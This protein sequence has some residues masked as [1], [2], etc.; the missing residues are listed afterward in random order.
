MTREA[1][2]TVEHLTKTFGDVVAV[3]D[4][5]FDVFKGEI[6]GLLGPN[7]AGKTT[8][9]D[10]LEGLKKASNGKLRV[11]GHDPWNDRYAI[12]QRI[13]VQLQESRLQARIKVSEALD[14]FA[15]FY[16]RPIEWDTLLE[17]L[18]LAEKRNAQFGTLSGGQKQRLFVALGMVG[19]GDLLFLDELTTGLDPQARHAMWELVRNL[20]DRGKTIVLTTH[21]M[22]EA[23]RLADRV[24]I[25]DHGKLVATDSPHGL[26]RRDGDDIRISFVAQ[27]GLDAKQLECVSGVARVEA[28]NG[29]VVV[30][31][32][33]DTLMADL[34]HKL[35]RLDCRPSDLRTENATLEDVFLKL[36]GHTFR[37]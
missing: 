11:L 1:V 20:R 25:M 35:Q 34:T 9:L 22:E 36:T 24:A 4:V 23:E 15:S 27:G 29:R 37:D 14:I 19:D 8:T 12:R 28:G 26:V 6:F 3:D 32:T 17:P 33:G 18:G 13:G 31:G 21:F 10:C 16:A 30:H 2:I 7:G 5:S